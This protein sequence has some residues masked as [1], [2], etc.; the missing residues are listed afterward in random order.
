MISKLAAW[1]RTRPEAIDRLRRALDEYLV[2]GIKTTLPFFR[3]LVRD[4]EFIEGNLDTGFISRFFERR[5]AGLRDE[6]STDDDEESETSRR[7]MALIVA[8][9]DY[10]NA[11]KRLS[12]DGQTRQLGPSQ[13]RLAGRDE[14][15]RRA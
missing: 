8:A 5:D 11:K 9:L 13:W 15:H 4:T 10:M 7:H 12:G 3:K 6:P 2:G 1:G 14:L